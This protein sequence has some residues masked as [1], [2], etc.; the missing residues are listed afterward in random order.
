MSDL[1]A[2]MYLDTSALVKLVKPEPGSAELVAL[3]EGTDLHPASAEIAELELLRSVR[4]HAPDRLERARRILDDLILL[5]LTR[6]IR[7]RAVTID[8]PTVRS[9][10]AIHLA[11][12]IEIRPHLSAVITYDNRMSEA[13][14][15]SGLPLLRPGA[16]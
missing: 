16:E 8:P 5:P 9:L 6:A 14:A 3:I 1:A 11:T 7:A 2:A 4:R 10:D 12:A 13:A 15:A